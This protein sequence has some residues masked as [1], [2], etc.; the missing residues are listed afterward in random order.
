MPER[1]KKRQRHFRPGKRNQSS[2]E[3]PNQPQKDNLNYNG[4]RPRK[5]ESSGSESEDSR[6]S[7]RANKK[8]RGKGT[9]PTP[10]SIPKKKKAHGIGSDPFH[11]TKNQ[12]PTKEDPTLANYKVF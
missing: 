1:R 11:I 5:A 9:S 12:L 2:N 3:D 6:K 4:K 7:R 8:A 10:K